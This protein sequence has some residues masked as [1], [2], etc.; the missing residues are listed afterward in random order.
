M[1]VSICIVYFTLS[2][3]MPSFVRIVVFFVVVF[4]GMKAYA[5]KSTQGCWVLVSAIL[6]RK[7]RPELTH[8]QLHARL[9]MHA[10][11]CTHT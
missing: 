7:V 3:W 9:H 4:L 6:L 2:V 11:T 10:H 1:L 5:E 8:A